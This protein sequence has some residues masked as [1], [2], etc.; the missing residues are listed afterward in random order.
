MGGMRTAGLLSLAIGAMIS[1]SL[2]TAC[3]QTTRA[4]G[5]GKFRTV[6]IGNPLKQSKVPDPLRQGVFL[7]PQSVSAVDVSDDG[8][9]VGVTTLAFRYD[10]N[11]WLLASNGEVRWG[12]Y[13]QPWAPFQAAVKPGWDKYGAQHAALI[14]RIQDIQ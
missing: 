5:G 3:A 4:S 6:Q 2:P 7:H 12:R 13:I 14:Q 11:F 1:G 10:R 9:F 8:G